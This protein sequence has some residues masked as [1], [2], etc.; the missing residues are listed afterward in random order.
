MNYY[1]IDEQGNK[2]DMGNNSLSLRMDCSNLNSRLGG[3]CIVVN[4]KTFRAVTF[5]SNLLGLDFTHKPQQNDRLAK[6]FK[7]SKSIFFTSFS[8]CDDLYSNVMSQ[9]F[10][11]TKSN[12]ELDWT[13]TKEEDDILISISF[14]EGDV[15]LY[16]ISDTDTK[17]SHFLQLEE[18]H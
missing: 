9:G 16:L 7:E 1:I 8:R 6:E 12:Q 5:Y 18:E 11:T 14:V 10:S 2:I 13:L 3:N 4:E 15:Y 17:I